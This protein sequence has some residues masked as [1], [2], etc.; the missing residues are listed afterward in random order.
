MAIDTEEKRRS[1]LF[2][3]LPYLRA[4]PV[5]DGTV[6]SGD[7]AHVLG[8]YSG[9]AGGAAPPPTAPDLSNLSARQIIKLIYE[10]SYRLMRITDEGEADTTVTYPTNTDMIWKR[11]YDPTTGAITVRR[12]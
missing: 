2:F 10:G 5:A 8:L 11:V 6:D 7:R 4:L 3:L 9:I 12:V 1:A